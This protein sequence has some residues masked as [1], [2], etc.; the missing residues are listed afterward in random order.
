MT[1]ESNL[2]P[3]TNLAT[4]RRERRIAIVWGIIAAALTLGAGLFVVESAEAYELP[5]SPTTMAGSP[6]ARTAR[7]SEPAPQ[8]IETPACAPDARSLLTVTNGNL[9]EGS[10]QTLSFAPNHRLRPDAAEALEALNVS[11]RAAFGRNLMVTSSYRSFAGQVTARETHG[12]LAADPGT[13]NHGWGIAVDLTDQVQAFHTPEHQWLRANAPTYGWHLPA[14]AREDGGL[15]EPWHWE[16][17]G[18]AEI[19]VDASGPVEINPAKW[20]DHNC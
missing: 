6:T 1:Y 3:Y 14:W 11:Y 20:L 7:T 4:K 19:P 12:H 15:P 10:L 18:P 13:S 9:S 16:F 8:L 17:H 5:S 2:I